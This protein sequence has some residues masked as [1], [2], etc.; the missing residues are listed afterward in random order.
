MK[1]Q[2]KWDGSKRRGGHNLASYRKVGIYKI[3]LY[4]LIS[5]TL[6]SMMGAFL[7]M[8]IKISSKSEH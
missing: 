1:S 4:D 2:K 6:F 5:L 7:L 3:C 8:T